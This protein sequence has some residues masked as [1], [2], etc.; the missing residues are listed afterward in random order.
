M[1]EREKV[2]E[3]KRWIDCLAQGIH[4]VTE[5]ILPDSDVV[6]NV[7]VSRCLFYVSDLL[8]RQLNRKFP[9][10]DTRFPSSLG[11]QIAFSAQPITASDLARHLSVAA[12]MPRGRKLSYRLLTD[13]L[14]AKG[15]L[16]EV[17]QS[18]G[19]KRRR[20]TPMGE[21]LG[22]VVEYCKDNERS[23]PVVLYK[24]SAQRFVVE[25]LDELLSY[26][27]GKP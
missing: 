11:A 5:E 7:R 10:E 13:W 25:H 1:T 18:D 12:Q 20:P 24:E 21:Q 27:V 22:I 9:E 2:E 6:N 19:R 3:A 15:L 14:M 8:R 17:I 26:A 16:R 23:Y 4:P